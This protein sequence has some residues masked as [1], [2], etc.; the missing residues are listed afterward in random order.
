MPH[1][2]Q[3]ISIPS[4]ISSTADTDPRTCDPGAIILVQHAIRDYSKT[5]N[6]PLMAMNA[7]E[8]SKPGFEYTTNATHSMRHDACTSVNSDVLTF[9]SASPSSSFSRSDTLVDHNDADSTTTVEG[10]NPSVAE[11]RLQFKEEFESSDSVEGLKDMKAMDEPLLAST[12]HFRFLTTTKPL[13]PAESA[14]NA[15]TKDCKKSRRSNGQKYNVYTGGSATDKI[16]STIL[17]GGVGRRS[18]LGGPSL[19]SGMV[20]CTVM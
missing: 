6:V 15:K 19:A 12:D 1:L 3:T 7:Q 18:M 11:R 10:T 17:E 2:A 5:D 14:K 16:A 9:R 20:G 8:T 13:K 4:R